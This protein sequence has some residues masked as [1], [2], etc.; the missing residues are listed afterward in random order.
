MKNLKYKIN[1]VI[2]LFILEASRVQFEIPTKATSGGS[3]RLCST[4]KGLY[5]LNSANPISSITISTSGAC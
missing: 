4:F 1:Y 3:N 2:T 5:G